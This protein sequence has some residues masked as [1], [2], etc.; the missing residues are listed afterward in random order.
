MKA[1][2]VIRGGP[3][4]PSQDAARRVGIN[5]FVFEAED[6]AYRGDDNVRAGAQSLFQALRMNGF[7]IRTMRDRTWH[8]EDGPLEVARKLSE[9]ITYFGGGA[10]GSPSIAQLASMYDGEIP[11]DSAF[12]AAVIREFFRRRPGRGLVWTLEAMQAGWI[13]DELVALINGNPLLVIAPQAYYGDMTPMFPAYVIENLV[14]RGIHREKI[15]L[16]LRHDR[17]DIGWYGIC[18]DH[19]KLA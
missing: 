13:S 1:S 8:S 7:R 5:E 14:N 17:L 12:H 9:D 11:H 19:G 3:Y 15:Q 4:V 2:L 16:F 18:Y 6:P 10:E